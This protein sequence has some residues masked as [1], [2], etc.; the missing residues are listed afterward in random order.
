M[1]IVL[2]TMMEMA[3]KKYSLIRDNKPFTQVDGMKNK[4]PLTGRWYIAFFPDIDIKAEDLMKNE[5]SGEE[6]YITETEIEFVDGI[7]FQGR[8]Y[9]LTP[10][11]ESP[12]TAKEKNSSFDK[13]RIDNTK[14][15]PLEI[16]LKN[17][18]ALQ[19]SE[20]LPLINKVKNLTAQENIKK[21]SL[22]KY[23]APLTQHKWL[24]DAVSIEILK[25]L[26]IDL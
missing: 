25:W 4:D 16:M 24:A 13:D 9:Y 10:E 15:F 3:G 8:A 5:K 12:D 22:S 23:K 1:S 18:T 2:K 7:E 26:G 17:I 6:F 20:L 11:E 14:E 21:D 19:Y